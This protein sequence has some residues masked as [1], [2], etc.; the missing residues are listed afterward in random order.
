MGKGKI[1][2]CPRDELGRF[3]EGYH[4]SPSTEFLKGENNLGW[5]DGISNDPDYKHLHYIKNREK[6]LKSAKNRN[7]QKKEEISKYYRG[8]RKKNLTS[9]S[10]YYRTWREN[11]R[12]RD[13]GRKRTWVKNHLDRRRKQ[14]RISNLMRAHLLRAVGSFT[15]EEWE[16][17]KR[18][19]NYT[20]PTCGRKEPE[21]KLTIDHIIPISKGGTNYIWNI[22]PLCLQCNVRKGNKLLVANICG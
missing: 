1:M 5:K 15:Y 17:L 22:H 12:E 10:D 19:H 21:I 6:Y 13:N 14:V 4:Y 7:G 16:I 2:S 3:I 18:K 9:L 8:W 11:N 20:C